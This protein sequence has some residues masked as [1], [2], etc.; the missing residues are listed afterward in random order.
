MHPL[1]CYVRNL[2]RVSL[3]SDASAWDAIVEEQYRR[4][5]D[6]TSPWR[7]WGRGWCLPNMVRELFDVRSFIDLGGLH[8]YYVTEWCFRS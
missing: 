8:S 3:S 6:L 4:R 2:V 5:A 1:W 7:F